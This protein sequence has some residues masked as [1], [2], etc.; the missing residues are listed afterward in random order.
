MSTDSL[1]GQTEDT[2]LPRRLRRALKK[3]TARALASEGRDHKL[4][5]HVKAK[6]PSDEGICC[7]RGG[8]RTAFQP[9]QIL[10]SPENI[11]NPTDI[12]PDPKPKVWTLSTL[13]FLPSCYIIST[14]TPPEAGQ[15]HTG[16]MHFLLGIN[17]RL[18]L[19]QIVAEISRC[20]CQMEV[21]RHERGLAG[22]DG[23]GF[24]SHTHSCPEA[25]VMA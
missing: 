9:L 10:G 19:R 8:T 6:I 18:G 22:H 20:R 5:T 1:A 14:C 23:G 12:R 24:T 11:P 15:F 13:L 7:A 21:A 4:C 3:A 2:R 16:P 25:W 17:W